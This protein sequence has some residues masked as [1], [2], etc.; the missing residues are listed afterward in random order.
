FFQIPAFFRKRTGA[1]AYL[2]AG[3]CPDFLMSFYVRRSIRSLSLLFKFVCN[4]LSFRNSSAKV[5]QIPQTPSVSAGKMR[6][7]PIPALHFPTLL[8]RPSVVAVFF[9]IVLMIT[10][11]WSICLY[12]PIYRP[13]RV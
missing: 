13:K 11:P 6:K 10:V 5:Q 4:S 12:Q 1:S 2:F 3:Q 9:C 8:S 7:S